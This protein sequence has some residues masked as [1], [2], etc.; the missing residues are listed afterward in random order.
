MAGLAISE[1]TTYRWSFEEDVR[2]YVAAG[3]PA[4]GVWRR[5]LADYGEERG[6]ELL[7][8]SGLEVSSLLWAGGFT[9][10]DGRSHEDS[11]A[12]ARDAI[13]L[14]AALKAPSLVVHSGARALHTQNHVRRL[15]TTALKKLLPIAEELGVTLAIEPMPA[16]CADEWTF[17]T[18]LDEA[19]RLV[20]SL[21]SEALRIALDTFHWGQNEAVLPRLA[22]LVP[23]L[24]LVQLGDGKEPPCDEQN[25]CRLGEGVVPLGQ[26][27]G[28]LQRGGY[29]GFFEVELLGEEI[30]ATNYG[31]LL[32][33]CRETFDS[34]TSQGS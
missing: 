27:I 22:E 14:A 30:E 21:E 34:L 24:S 9:G 12:D 7:A 23:Y 26:I 8:D 32:A 20:G 16:S 31:Q 10:S 6:I 1:V 2:Q 33:H 18:D 4:I 3:I 19:V 17:L 28:D 15:L 5:K 11:I 25:R 29:R 13:H